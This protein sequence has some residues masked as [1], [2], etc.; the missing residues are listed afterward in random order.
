M[1]DTKQLKLMDLQTLKLS[2]AELSQLPEYS[3]TLPT[4]TI[5]GKRWRRNVTPGHNGSASREVDPDA[6]WIV[7]EYVESTER[8]YVAIKW[9]RVAIKPE[10]TFLAGD[11]LS[12]QEIAWLVEDSTNPGCPDCESDDVSVDH[13][14]S[15]GGLSKPE[16]TCNHCGSQFALEAELEGL[17]LARHSPDSARVWTGKRLTDANP[18]AIS[19]N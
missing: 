17:K 15:L 12:P 19:I 14:F 18:K 3:C 2:L 7:G 1:P 13:A 16:Y 11:E 5:L 6:T 8:G 9:Y 10:R 4:G